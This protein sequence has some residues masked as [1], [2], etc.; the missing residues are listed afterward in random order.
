M[1]RKSILIYCLMTFLLGG[2]L[3]ADGKTTVK[4]FTLKKAIE[5]GLKNSPILK[6]EDAKI[7]GIEY[8][9]GVEKSKK[10]PHV[11]LAGNGIVSRMNKPIGAYEPP[12]LKYDNV[13]FDCTVNGNYLLYDFKTI[14]YRIK[15]LRKKI[16][17]EELIKGQKEDFITFRIATLFLKILTY[18]DLIDAEKSILKSL[19]ELR[20]DVKNLIKF[21]KA[22]EVDLLKV[23]T[24]IAHEESNLD[25]LKAEREADMSEL[26]YYM[27]YTGEFKLSGNVRKL[28]ESEKISEDKFINEGLK[29]RKDLLALSFTIKS[30]EDSMESV[31][32][33]KYPTVSLF[34]GFKST[35]LVNP[36]SFKDIMREVM[37]NPNIGEGG[38]GHTQSDW[39]AGFHVNFPVYDGGFRK[40]KF[41]NLSS[42]KSEVENRISDKK[43]E[44]ISRI[45]KA[46]ARFRS[47]VSKAKA[48]RETVKQA[49]ETLR[50]EKLKY[51][52]GKTPI[53]FVLEAEAELLKTKALLSLAER[54]I[55]ISY[56]D[57]LFQSGVIG[58]LGF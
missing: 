28:S 42:K 24:A 23:E 49:K 52:Y 54:G 30:I 10:R 35:L 7:R 43:N 16:K 53:N 6:A 21:G 11:D 48:L 47:N 34:S 27:G 26:A 51:K 13:L 20:R 55:E 29:K 1:N 57:I 17:A 2:I 25:T 44:I 19:R 8:N 32:R 5:Y 37:N 50:V 31:K 38:T 45:K 12:Y 56:L 22:I 9:I 41:F 4:K 33:S 14:D 46:I 39:Y 15:S 36:T 18:D 3:F 40:N 58:S